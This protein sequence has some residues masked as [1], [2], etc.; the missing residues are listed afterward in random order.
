MDKG[1]EILNAHGYRSE[2]KK[3]YVHNIVQIR[4]KIG[5][6]I[7]HLE[8][9]LG[10]YL[11]ALEDLEGENKNNFIRNRINDYLGNLN[12]VNLLREYEIDYYID[13][14]NVFLQDED[15][16]EHLRPDQLELLFHR[17]KTPTHKEKALFIF[18]GLLMLPH[19][20]IPQMLHYQHINQITNGKLDFGEYLNAFNEIENRLKYVYGRCLNLFIYNGVESFEIEGL[21]YGKPIKEFPVAENFLTLK[22]TLIFEINQEYEIPGEIEN[23]LPIMYTKKGEASSSGAG[24]SGAGS[25]Q[26]VSNT[27]ERRRRHRDGNGGNGSR[28]SQ[29]GRGNN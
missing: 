12:H 29:R 18:Y 3:E 26:S 20:L 8:S 16:T 10:A 28:R 21:T 15:F 4:K 6:V 24:S 1:K 27:G 9:I 13:S 11:N 23:Y 2:D 17:I 25:G 19:I 22:I 14:N 5:T 7:A